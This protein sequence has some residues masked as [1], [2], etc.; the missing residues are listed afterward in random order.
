[1]A[2][3][4]SASGVNEP[5]KRPL[6]PSFMR[7]QQTRLKALELFAS[8]G[9]G[10]TSMRE[11]AAHMGLS[12]GSLYNHIESKQVLLFELIEELYTC[13]VKGLARVSPARANAQDRLHKLLTIHIELHSKMALYFLVA[14][15]EMHC[16]DEEQTE[17]IQQLRATYENRLAQLLAECACV[18]ISPHLRAL[19]KSSVSLLNNLPSWF[20]PD[21]LDPASRSRL[22][23]SIV[24]TSIAGT[25]EELKCPPQSLPKKHR[26]P[27]ETL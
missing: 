5:L 6:Q 22:M 23:T 16:L 24:R 8:R 13:L 14:E 27:I 17:A 11:L 9:F 4:P 12:P 18:D 10:Q 19:A 1:M 21:Q 15:R 26:Q 20:A 3:Q 2:T 25:L 7:P